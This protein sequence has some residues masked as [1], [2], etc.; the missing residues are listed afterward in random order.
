MSTSY[1]GKSRFATVCYESVSLELFDP[2]CP[3]SRLINS[4]ASIVSQNRSYW[5]TMPS[6]RLSPTSTESIHSRFLERLVQLKSKIELPY[7]HA[8]SPRL[9]GYRVVSRYAIT[10]LISC[11]YWPMRW[12]H[13]VCCP[14]RR[15]DEPLYL[16][17]INPYNAGLAAGI[18]IK[19]HLCSSTILHYII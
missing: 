11:S 16:I 4:T 17:L 8:T 3:T 6:H 12:V 2:R 7:L 15:Y 14:L 5:L 18:L 1:D 9:L 19:L 13:I 10:V